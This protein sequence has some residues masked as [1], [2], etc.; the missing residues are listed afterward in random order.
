MHKLHVCCI[1]LAIVL[2]LLAQTEC[3]NG[4]S[5]YNPNETVIITRC[6]TT[7]RSALLAFR[8]GL[9]DPAN[10]L[11]SWEGDDCCRWKGVGC[12]NRTGRVVKLDLQGDCGN[13][14]ISKQVLG[15]SISDSLLDLH[16]LQ[17]LDLSCNRF[18]GQQVPKFLS[19][20]HSLRYLD[21]SQSSF[22]GRI[23]PQLGNL[24]SLR[25]FSIDSIFGDTDSTD[26]SWLSRLS[27]LEYL[28]MSFVNLST[29]VHWVPTVNMIRSLEFL[30]FSFCEL[31]TSPDSL[32]HSNL[33]SLETLD[34]SC[35][36]FNKYVSSN[37]FWNVTSLKHLD[38]S[39]CQHHGRFP[40]QLGRMTSI[41]VLDL[42]ENNLVGMIPSNLNNLCN[43]EE[44]LLC[45]INI[46]GSIAEFF[47][48]LPDC[49]RSKLQILLL[50]MSNLTRSLPAKL[51]PFSNLTWLDLLGP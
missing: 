8:A 29:V 41:V 5:A 6:I 12:S 38:V 1:Q 25:Y 20:L 19:S 27:S 18:N 14:I 49:S 28:D 36:R 45:E 39:S 9:S 15:G 21:L 17:Y 3:S 34:I 42:S 32:L 46:N 22:S 23:P 33:T 48:R 16:H 11:P 2:F 13:S 44:L 35:N 24:S 31:Q 26:I 30:C 43:L 50:R 47:E 4:T 10:L 7:E 51:E 37:W 40:D